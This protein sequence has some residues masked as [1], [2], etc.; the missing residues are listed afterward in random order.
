MTLEKNV[1]DIVRDNSSLKNL[2]LLDGHNYPSVVNTLNKLFS[3]DE[4][5]QFFIN[6]IHDVFTSNRIRVSNNLFYI[7]MFGK[8]NAYFKESSDF[9]YNFGSFVSGVI[10]LALAEQEKMLLGNNYKTMSLNNDSWI[11]F[12]KKGPALNKR[13]FDF[14]KIISVTLRHEVKMYFKHLLKCE[15]NFRN[16][17]GFALLIA[18]CNNLTS[19]FSEILYFKDIKEKHIRSLINKLE[20]GEVTTEHNKKYSIESIRKMIQKCSSVVNFLIDKDD[21]SNRPF[22]NNLSSVIFNNTSSHSKNTEIIPEEVA[23]QIDSNLDSLNQNHQLIYEILSVTGLRFKEVSHL[24]FDCIDNSKYTNDYKMLSYTPY[25]TLNDRKRSGRDDPPEVA[26][27]NELATKIKKMILHTEHVRKITETPFIFF[28][29]QTGGN[30]FFLV[31]ESA[32]VEAINRLIKFHNIHSSDGGLWHYSSRQ[33]RKTLAVNLVEEGAT[34]NEIAMQFGHA[35]IRTTEKYYAEV[36]KKK[37]AEMNSSFFKK[38]FMV[39]VGEE[40]LKNYSEE[41]RKQLY[42]DFSLNSREVEFGKCSKHMSEGPC[43]IRTGAMSCATCPKLCTGLNYL[44]KWT[45]LL[46]SQ[47]NIV[48]ELLRIYN[49]ELISAN[50]YEEFIEYQ[51]EI[52]LLK[53]YQ[54]VVDTIMKSREVS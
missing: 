44:E 8:G 40:N 43:G 13:E 6:F 42:V 48:E 25:K 52:K 16:D 21:Y 4:I 51:K 30:R 35:D 15:T 36:R 33:S 23:S 47:K 29:K 10:D 38:R 5:E 2:I 24:T 53:T 28:G 49:K 20:V 46:D 34:V 12:F 32:F 7:E 54:D 41:E 11:L 50:E 22:V 1:S 45:E 31:Q 26:I 27:P 14:S 3:K 19:D 9:T 18:A 17:K 39:F 37:L